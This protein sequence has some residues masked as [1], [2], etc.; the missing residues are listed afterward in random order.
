[1]K[2]LLFFNLCVVTLCVLITYYYVNVINK[3]NTKLDYI[4]NEIEKN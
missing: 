1:M 2:N 4:K 3:M